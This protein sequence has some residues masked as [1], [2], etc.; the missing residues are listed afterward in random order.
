MTITLKEDDICKLYK[1][2]KDDNLVRTIGTEI[3]ALGSVFEDENN[4]VQVFRIDNDLF[5]LL[6]QHKL[7]Y[8][9][10]SHAVDDEDNVVCSLL[11][12][13]TIPTGFESNNSLD[14]K[15]KTSSGIL[16]KSINITQIMQENINLNY[17]LQGGD[18]LKHRNGEKLNQELRNSKQE[19]FPVRL[20]YI[21]QL[22]I[23]REYQKHN[24]IQ[25]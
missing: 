6:S 11:T 8:A 20:L 4:N 1:D 14:S 3:E 5:S 12:Y 21:L 7:S 17:N 25:N 2:L 22:P 24:H 23:Q 19:K 15:I 10:I 13:S 9:Y 16:N 18:Q